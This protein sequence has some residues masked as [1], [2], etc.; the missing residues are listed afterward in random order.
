M[1]HFIV[2]D[3]FVSPQNSCVKVLDLSLGLDLRRWTVFRDRAFKELT[4]LK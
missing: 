3:K 1:K 2:M 4:K